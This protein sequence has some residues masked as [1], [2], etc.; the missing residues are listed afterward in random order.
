MNIDQLNP[1]SDTFGSFP[2]TK[3]TVSGV[4]PTGNIAANE[5]KSK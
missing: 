4:T 3:P 1:Y 2:V 5:F